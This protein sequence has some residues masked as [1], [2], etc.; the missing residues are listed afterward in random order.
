MQLRERMESNPNY[1]IFAGD[2]RYISNFWMKFESPSSE[3]KFRKTI[4]NRSRNIV[5]FLCIMECILL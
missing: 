4:I 5:K 1:N 2:K 3:D